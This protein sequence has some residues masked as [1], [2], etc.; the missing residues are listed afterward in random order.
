MGATAAFARPTEGE[1]HVACNLVHD[2]GYLL[3]GCSQVIRKVIAT[4]KTH[5]MMVRKIPS[6]D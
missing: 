5:T 1:R 6:A 2:T 3:R 4:K